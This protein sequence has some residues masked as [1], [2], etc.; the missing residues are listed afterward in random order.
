MTKHPQKEATMTLSAV[1]HLPKRSPMTMTTK[2]PLKE[3]A[4]TAKHPLV[5]T[6]AMRSS[7]T[8]QIIAVDHRHTL[9]DSHTRH[10]EPTTW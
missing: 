1:K 10:I 4:T 5:T 3:K 6:L 8:G 2:H 9:S 7:V